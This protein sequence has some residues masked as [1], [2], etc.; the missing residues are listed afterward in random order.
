MQKAVV[1][2]KEGV[3]IQKI[4]VFHF[5]AVTSCSSTRGSHV[6]GM[7]AQ[8]ALDFMDELD[9]NGVEV[10]EL[11]CSDSDIDVISSSEEEDLD[12]DILGSDDDSDGHTSCDD[13]AGHLAGHLGAR[14]RG[15][16]GR[17]RGGRGQGGR[18]RGWK[19]ER[20]G[21]GRRQPCT[22]PWTRA[23]RTAT[24]SCCT[25]KITFR[26]TMTIIPLP[27]QPHRYGHSRHK[28]YF[29]A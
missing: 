20:T 26:S 1:A 9:A 23:W 14:G 2:T 15:V 28:T 25:I 24:V 4:V 17:G 7:D 11:R 8:A 3:A 21:S 27:T 10:D 19:R 6:R 29:I 16:R 18:G 5:V 12:L 22:R 13:G